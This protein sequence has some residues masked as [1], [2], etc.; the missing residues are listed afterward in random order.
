[1]HP[2]IF[3]LTSVI[4]FSLKLNAHVLHPNSL[5]NPFQSGYSRRADGNQKPTNFSSFVTWRGTDNQQQSVYCLQ[6]V[7]VNV[8]HSLLFTDIMNSC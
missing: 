4:I 8:L 3:P 7:S 6:I 2:C 5:K 1:M